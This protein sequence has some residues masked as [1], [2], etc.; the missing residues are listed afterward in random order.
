MCWFFVRQKHWCEVLAKLLAKNF[1]RII[2]DKQINPFDAIKLED[3]IEQLRRTV[4][5]LNQKKKE[6]KISFIL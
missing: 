1:R 5:E 6:M 4:N 3:A 2:E